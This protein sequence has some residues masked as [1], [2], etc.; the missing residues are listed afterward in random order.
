MRGLYK[1]ADQSFS[2]PD[3]VDKAKTYG[4]QNQ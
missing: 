4:S 1:S 3:A 2:G